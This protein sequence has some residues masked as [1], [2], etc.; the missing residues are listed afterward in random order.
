[1]ETVLGRGA[2]PCSFPLEGTCGVIFRRSSNPGAIHNAKKKDDGYKAPQRGCYLSHDIVVC[3]T[4]PQT[5][6]ETNAFTK[7]NFGKI[8]ATSPLL[9]GRKRPLPSIYSHIP[10]FYL[11]R[12]K[13]TVG[14]RAII[15]GGSTH[16]ACTEQF[17]TREGF[18]VAQ[19]GNFVIE[20]DKRKGRHN[21]PVRA[22]NV[23]LIFSYVARPPRPSHGARTPTSVD[24]K[25]FE[26][27]VCSVFMS[28]LSR[29]SLPNNEITGLGIG[30]FVFM[31][32]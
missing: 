11:W 17:R 18:M 1:M 20:R 9:C 27:V 5:E 8:G 13:K 24:F 30:S 23:S 29:R 28:S 25:G 15:V 26:G 14:I 3:E 32:R 12:E 21:S 7:Q 22:L 16:V 2:R 31:E 19:R 10:A 4:F 6:R